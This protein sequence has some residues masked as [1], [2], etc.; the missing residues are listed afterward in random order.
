MGQKLLPTKELVII[1]DIRERYSNVIRY[2][3]ECNANVVFKRLDIADYICSERVGIERKT[4]TDF[5]Q[6]IMD[7]R[8]FNQMEDMGKA[9][10]AP[11]LIIEGMQDSIFL[12]RS[13]H[14]NAIRGAI[15]AITIDYH[16]PIIWTRGARETA[17]QIFWI[18]KR[19]AEGKRKE[20][21]IR[22]KKKSKGLG[23]EQEFLV[24]GLPGI[25]T[26][27]SKRLLSAFRNPKAIFNAS[28]EEL[29]KIEGI[30]KEK[31]KRIWDVVNKRYG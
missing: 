28:I 18:A 6:S 15:A 22:I 27:L 17:M 9:F 1:V 25:N 2:L 11:L 21:Q 19:E 23:Y 7:K 24:S 12:Q 29:M 31:A 5:I 13:V 20:L 14:P 10:D 30:G 26:K 4:V 8:I 3:S 16:I